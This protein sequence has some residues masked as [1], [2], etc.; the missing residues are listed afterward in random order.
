MFD[1]VWHAG[2]WQVLRSFSIAGGLV[3]AIR[4]L[5]ENSSS[6]EQS[7]R[8][9][10]Q[11]NSWCPSEMLTPTYS[12]LLVPREPLSGELRTQKLKSHLMRI[13][14]LNVLPLKP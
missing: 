6:S 1:R 7:A 14:S 12:V 11:D 13:Q 2:L 5:Y 10:L 4:A 9:V 8:E 3:Q